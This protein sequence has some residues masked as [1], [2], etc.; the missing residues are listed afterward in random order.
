MFNALSCMLC[1][2]FLG[3]H[4]EFGSAAPTFNFKDLIVLVA[5]TSFADVANRDIIFSKIPSCKKECTNEVPATRLINSQFTGFL[6][7]LVFGSSHCSPG[8]CGSSGRGDGG[9]HQ[10]QPSCAQLQDAGMA[11][12]VLAKP[13]TRRGGRRGRSKANVRS[14]G[15]E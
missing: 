3:F 13:R 1:S 15:D 5:V 9:L 4:N 6:N 12:E 11:G 10:G 14:F 8:V 7:L 2:G